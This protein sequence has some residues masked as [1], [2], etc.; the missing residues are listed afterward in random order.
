M[1]ETHENSG[2][3]SAVIVRYPGIPASQH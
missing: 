2:G 1:R 3:G